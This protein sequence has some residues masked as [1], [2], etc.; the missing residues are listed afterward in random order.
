[1][2]QTSFLK[3]KNKIA[4]K[5]KK[6]NIFYSD[7][8]SYSNKFKKILKVNTLSFLI[9]EN[10]I[11]SAISY[12]SL[13]NNNFPVCLIDN[14]ILD[15][16]FFKLVS[17][18]NPRYIICNKKKNLK[19]INFKINK[20]FNL[21]NFNIY[22]IDHKKKYSISKK[23][24]L[25]ISTSGSLNEP[26]FVKL[27]KRNLETNTKGIVKYLGINSR[28]STITTMPMHYSYGL[29]VINSH[30]YAGGK[31]ILTDKNLL[32]KNFYEIIKKENLTNFN[33]VPFIYEIL[34]KIGLE[35]II[36]KNL[37]FLTLA[38][39]SLSKDKILKIYNLLK[40]KN[41]SFFTMYGQ[42]EASP[43]ISYLLIN[44]NELKK[45]NLSIGKCIFGGKLYL[46]RQNEIIFEGPNVYG[47][48]ASSYK[49]LKKY[50]KVNK[51]FTK[52]IGFKNEY[53]EIYITGRL[54][55]SIKVYGHRVNL[56]YLEKKIEELYKCNSAVILKDKKI[57]IFSEKKIEISNL[58]N[59]HSNIFQNIV[60]SKIPLNKNMK[61]NYFLLQSFKF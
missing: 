31:I 2:F 51:L 17:L 19:F 44:E 16:D 25:L 53:D 32:S 45:D 56:D 12:V 54:N 60:L 28:D 46:S 13:L 22:K 48:Y 49:D 30:I 18:F 50:K 35:K 36:F 40:N 61:K 33:G 5:Q 3:N 20:I 47:G 34:L 14:N 42:T 6:T 26:K 7:L 37:K 39:G 29:S 43:R 4:F 8:I 55:R 10:Q 24:S 59:L 21:Y 38:G 27:S 23:I 52:D 58:T 11:G 57:I 41:V 15:T 9:C 1:M